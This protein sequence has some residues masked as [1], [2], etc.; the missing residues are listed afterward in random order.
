MMA[1]PRLANGGRGLLLAVVLTGIALR[2]ALTLAASGHPERLL[3]PDSIGYLDLARNLGAFLATDGPD[4]SLSLRR[5]PGYPVFLHLLTETLSMGLVGAMVVQSAL[6]GLVAA[7]VFL[8]G[9]R[10]HSER[11]GL[12]AAAVV[13]FDP[14]SIAQGPLV[15]TEGLFT[16]LVVLAVLVVLPAARWPVP[17][18]A[19]VSG[20]LVGTATLVRP[21]G[22]LLAPVIALA[23]LT[24]RQPLRQRLLRA[25]SLLAVAGILIGGWMMHNGAR[26][27]IRTLSTVSAVNLLDYRAAGVAGIRDP[28][29]TTLDRIVGELDSS[30]EVAR[31]DAIVHERLP[32]DAT[33]ADEHRVR[34]EVAREVLLAD[35][36]ASIR[37]G[38]E[39]LIRN[40][41]R[42]AS[43]GRSQWQI[44][45]LEREDGQVPPLAWGL[46]L[47]EVLLLVA[48]YLAA[49]VGIRALLQDRRLDTLLLLL[50]PGASLLV[51]SSGLESYS[52][53]RG[54]SIPFIAV[55][56]GIG[57]A[58]RRDRAT[59]HRVHA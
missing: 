43:S 49:L 18:A 14:A 52:R 5:P 37:V 42:P 59:S 4:L 54:P 46:A 2:V 48:L 1:R 10:L 8:V 28:D 16:L 26:A 32:A 40:L 38:A 3:Q 51:L 44:L 15:L 47:V 45:G 29:L 39:G 56:A 20:L 53:F 57:L 58:S 6:V 9:V 31:L 36:V 55:L 35:P 23:L 19:G 11:A 25:G 13:A 17:L 33:E 12:I 30:G 34:S 27:D 7:L 24:G 50:L 21:I 22:L 41:F